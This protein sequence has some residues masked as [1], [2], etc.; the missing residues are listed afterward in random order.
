M[1]KVHKMAS[2]R[3]RLYES[4]TDKLREFIALGYPLN[5]LRAVC[6]LLAF[7]TGISTWITVRNDIEHIDVSRLKQA[8]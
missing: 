4:A 8:A 6:N 1:R 2:N 7:N 3:R 5:L